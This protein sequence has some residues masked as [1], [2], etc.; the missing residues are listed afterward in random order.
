MLHLIANASLNYIEANIFV[1]VFCS[2]VFFLN[3]SEIS[4]KLM[5]AAKEK[6]SPT[7]TTQQQLA[8]L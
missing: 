1:A 5:I 4:L 2:L 7:K 6:N 8:L 3:A